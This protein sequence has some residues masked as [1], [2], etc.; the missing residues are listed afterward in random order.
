MGWI[1]IAGLVFWL[2]AGG[3]KGI[4]IWLDACLIAFSCL[5]IWHSFRKANRLK[6]MLSESE[7]K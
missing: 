3:Y 6:S 2:V 5:L 7:K 4:P 1:Y